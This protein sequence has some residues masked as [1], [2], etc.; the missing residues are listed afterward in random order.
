MQPLNA[1]EYRRQILGGEW[2]FILRCG[3]NVRSHPAYVKTGKI[4]DTGITVQRP[5]TPTTYHFDCRTSINVLNCYNSV[6]FAKSFGDWKSGTRETGIFG[7]YEEMKEIVYRANP[8]S[9]SLI[10]VR[11]TRQLEKGCCPYEMENITP[12][13][14]HELYK[15][16]G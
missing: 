16:L 12:D 1:E 8:C 5:G 3:L 7:N 9:Q 13:E 4:I 6:I 2:S 14:M 10:D 11:T 15:A